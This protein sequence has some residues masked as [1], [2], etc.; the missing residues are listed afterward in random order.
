MLNEY[1]KLLDTL[2]ILATGLLIIA[3]YLFLY[4][5]LKDKQPPL[6][7]MHEY[8]TSIGIITVVL[9]FVL[10]Q[11]RFS[12][13]SS[14]VTPFSILRQLA[15]AHFLALLTYG[16]SAYIFKLTHLS[17]L[18]L[19]GGL[20]LSALTS[21]AW[22]LGAYALYRAI[23]RRGWNMKK[24]LLIGGPDATMPLLKMIDADAALG[25]TVA[26]VLPLKPGQNLGEI[27][28]ASAVDCVIFTT[29]REHPDLIEKAIEACSE[30]G[31]Q[32]M[33]R[34][35]FVQEAWAFSG[36]SYL[37]DM[38]LLVFSMTPEEGLASLC[39]RLI[40]TAVS[41]LLLMLLALPMLVLA[42]LIQWTSRGPALFAQKRVGLNGAAFSMYKFRSMQDGAENHAAR[43]SLHNEMRG[44]VF[45]MKQDPRLTFLGGFL[46]KYSL[47]E[48]PQLWNVLKGDMSLVGPR[49]PLTSEVSKYKGWQRRRLSMRPG[50]TGLWQVLGRQKLIDFDAWVELDLKYIDHWSLWLDLKIIFQTIPAV[51]KGTGM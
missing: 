7:A 3:G 32:L 22:H 36:I 44:P 2:H 4:G 42:L 31:I 40:D 6:L 5:M 11:R 17:R 33:L 23:R 24:A 12:A 27:L 50:I 10:S 25:L 15:L 26:S 29:C 20:L 34:P 49:P 14:F 46:R 51:V 28:D 37:H 13:I 8:L 1:K 48:L 9:M 19:L 21:G 18:Y 47:D 35:D 30:R 38:P 39:K 41:A 43:V 45:K 16:L